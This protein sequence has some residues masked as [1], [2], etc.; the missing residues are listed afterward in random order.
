MIA[1]GNDTE[2]VRVGNYLARDLIIDTEIADRNH[3][4]SVRRV[5][6]VLRRILANTNHEIE[7]PYFTFGSLIL[8]QVAGDFDESD[9]LAQRL[10]EDEANARNNES[11]NWEIVDSRF[12]F[13]L[14]S[15]DQLNSDWMSLASK[16]SNPSN[17]TNLQLVIDAIAVN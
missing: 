3:V 5:F 14:T 4:E 16:L 2:S 15:Y 13:G 9:L 11:L 7:Y 6:P 1:F 12:L 10:I 17:D 8:A